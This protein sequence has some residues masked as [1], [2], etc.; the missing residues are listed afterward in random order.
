MQGFKYTIYLLLFITFFS[1]SN[2]E[3][4][5]EPIRETYKHTAIIYMSADNNLSQNAQNGIEQLK[6]AQLNEEHNLIVYIDSND[7]L[8]QLLKIEN[9]EA[10]VVKTYIEQNSADPI[11]LNYILND[12]ANIFPSDTYGLVLWSHGSSW[13]PPQYQTR[14]FGSDNY[15]EMDISELAEALPIKYKYIIFDAC[16]MGGIEVL[17]ELK[18]KADYI[19]SSPTEIL[20][21]GF[22]YT[23]IAPY[24]FLKEEKDLIT[25]S[26]LFFNHYNNMS[27][28]YKSASISLVK[29]E[30]LQRLAA[31]NN[32]LI[33]KYP[34]TR[35]EY[36]QSEI[37]SLD[38][39]SVSLMY[40]YQDFLSKNYPENLL[41]EINQTL[42]E[43]VLYKAH[44]DKFLNKLEIKSFSGISC[45]VP[46]KR[47]TQFH[48]YYKSL[49]WS[50]YSGWHL[51]L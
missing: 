48:N 28:A 14:S 31:L 40:D 35:W 29:T 8:P 19:I 44:T 41:K 46:N 4:Y 18:D 15:N 3:D 37:Q 5:S 36:N 7:N 23:E 11:I 30:R 49:K 21:L 22:P 43:L 50:Y 20:T 39:Y 33:N 27:G 38:L 45:Y 13:L 9:N 34:L 26:E 25:I 32:E 24:L 51:L 6:K 16:F 1:C 47:Y 2:D 42:N 17:Y 12:I 10:K